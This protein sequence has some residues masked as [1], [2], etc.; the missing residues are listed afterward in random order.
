MKEEEV[1]S[2]AMANVDREVFFTG[3]AGELY[4]I[5]YAVDPELEW[6]GE[7]A[8]VTEGMFNRKGYL[9]LLVRLDM[10][11]GSQLTIYA[12]EDRKPYRKIWQ[13]AATNK[14]TLLIPIRL[15]RCDRW[16]LKLSGVGE[17]TVRGIARE[18]VTGSVK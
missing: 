6:Y 15:G 16:Q 9:K 11:A 18:H 8:E 2:L 3:G 17:V 1:Q 14:T 7:F 10:T 4:V 5:G 13:Q 12:R